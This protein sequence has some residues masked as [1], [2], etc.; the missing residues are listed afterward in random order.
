MNYDTYLNS[1]IA[2]DNSTRPTWQYIYALSYHT[3]HDID[4]R[5]KG[6]TSPDSVFYFRSTVA[7]DAYRAIFE[8]VGGLD[9]KE[10]TVGEMRDAS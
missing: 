4:R 2:R 1:D 10:W 7:R 3:R 8:Q 5:E 9:F 6:I